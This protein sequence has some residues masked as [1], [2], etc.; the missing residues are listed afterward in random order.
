MI[1]FLKSVCERARRRTHTQS[2]GFA[3]ACLY[4]CY[5]HGD[6]CVRV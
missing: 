4:V 3:Y 1:L 2:P 5:V 6:A